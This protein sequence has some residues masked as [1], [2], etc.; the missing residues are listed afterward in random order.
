MYKLDELFTCTAIG[1]P[2]P[3]VLLIVKLERELAFIV[4]L[5]IDSNLFTQFCLFIAKLNYSHL[6]ARVVLN[7]E[8]QIL[9]AINEIEPCVP[10]TKCIHLN[11]YL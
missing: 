6:I 2:P 11:K 1:F 9:P 7:L 3:V 4:L 8:D 5:V 10:I